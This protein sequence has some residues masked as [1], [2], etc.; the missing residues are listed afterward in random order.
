MEDLVTVVAQVKKLLKLYSLRK[1][2]S[3]L[4][5]WRLKLQSSNM[6]LSL[7]EEAFYFSKKIN[8]KEV[9]PLCYKA[10]QFSCF[11]KLQG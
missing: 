8:Q 11:Q 6:S 10:D 7:L 1:Y 5:K 9:Q 4:L 2:Y 3:C